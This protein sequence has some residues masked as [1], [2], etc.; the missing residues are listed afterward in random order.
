[1]SFALEMPLFWFEKGNINVTKIKTNFCIQL[2][3]STVFNPSLLSD[4]GLAIAA[5]HIL[6]K[7]IKIVL[8]KN[9][10]NYNFAIYI[11]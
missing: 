5:L 9:V 6:L 10:K 4:N 7:D 8:N 3:S 1:M 2:N 11:S